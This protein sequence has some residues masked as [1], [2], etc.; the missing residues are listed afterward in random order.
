MSVKGW[1]V[2]LTLPWLVSLESEVCVSV[3]LWDTV[4]CR[5]TP[6]VTHMCGN[7]SIILI[8]GLNPTVIACKNWENTLGSGGKDG[9]RQNWGGLVTSFCAAWVSRLCG[10]TPDMH[11]ILGETSSCCKH[12]WLYNRDDTLVLNEALGF[13]HLHLWW[14]ETFLK[15]IRNSRVLAS[16]R[17]SSARKKTRMNNKHGRDAIPE[18]EAMTSGHEWSIMIMK[19]GAKYTGSH[20]EVN[21]SREYRLALVFVYTQQMNICV[22][23]LT[24]SDWT[25]RDWTF[26]DCNTLSLH[27]IYK[28]I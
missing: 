21:M 18:S 16:H 24:G 23:N 9:N 2:E 5:Y 3:L 8:C 22:Q 25:G 15:H 7:G 11:G 19:T 26:K 1:W 17:K 14:Q 6:P 12:N 13:V 10:Q 20:I 28:L 4:T 27:Y